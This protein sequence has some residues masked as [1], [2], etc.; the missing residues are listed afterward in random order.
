[1]SIQVGLQPVELDPTREHLS[2]LE[3]QVA[4]RERELS[5]LKVELQELQSRYL[6]EVGSL[7]GAQRARSGG[8]RSGSACRPAPPPD[9]IGEKDSGPEQGPALESGC[10]N[11]SAPSDDLKRVFR[12]VAKAV[13][14]DLALDESAR[15]R[16]HSLMAEANRAY[17]ERDEDRLRLILRVWERSPESVIGDDPEAQRLRLSR[18]VTELEEH[19]LALDLELTDLRASAIARLQKKIHDARAQGWDLFAEMIRQ[20]RSEI[21]GA[22][23]QLA[24]LRR[25]ESR[26]TRRP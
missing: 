21:A 7:Y 16:R 4:E 2:S 23:A 8:R 24:S 10:T 15:W 26:R 13:H 12:D 22:K 6:S 20:V 14:P 18:R 1:M 19:L 3:L 9:E 17:A 25:S 11:R 5:E